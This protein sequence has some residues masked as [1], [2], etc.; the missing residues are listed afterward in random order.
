MIS[1]IETQLGYETAMAM[2]CLLVEQ[3]GM[4]G[5][6]YVDLSNTKKMTEYMQLDHEVD[7]SGNV[8]IITLKK[9]KLS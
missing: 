9:G 8:A 5:R 3:Y 7:S 1:K 6:L 4:D 2:L